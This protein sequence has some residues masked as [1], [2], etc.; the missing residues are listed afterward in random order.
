MLGSSRSQGR[1]SGKLLVG[2]VSTC[3]ALP[4][5]L[6][7]WMRKILIASS[8]LMIF[9]VL[10][11]LVQFKTEVIY[12]ETFYG[13]FEVYDG[14]EIS[15]VEIKIPAVARTDGE[16]VGVITTLKVLAIP[17]N[18]RTLTNIENLLFWVDTQH[19]IRTAKKVASKITGMDLSKIDIIYTIETNASLIGGESAGAAITIATV[20]ALRNKSLNESVIIT[21]T[22]DEGGNVGEV[23]GIILKGRAAKK[24]GAKL[25]LVPR[26]QGIIEDYEPIEKCEKIGVITLCRIEYEAKE[27]NVE[28]VVGIKV[29]EVKNIEDALKYFII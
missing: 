8:I 4:A 6:S 14:F 7:D 21:G 17:G 1:Y 25:Y 29:I 2:V 9:A 12:N 5:I 16:E 11:P 10:S 26:G 18:G 24:Y 3:D 27:T 22:I 28:E 15:E 13:E 23:G 19:S 20:A